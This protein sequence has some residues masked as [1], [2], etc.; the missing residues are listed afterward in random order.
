[1]NAKIK[2]LC[3][4]NLVNAVVIFDNLYV[5]IDMPIAYVVNL[6]SVYEALHWYLWSLTEDLK[7]VLLKY[8]FVCWFKFHWVKFVP[9][10]PKDPKS[11]WIQAMAFHRTGDKTSGKQMKAQPN[12]VL[13][14]YQASDSAIIWNQ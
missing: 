11:T 6:R 8:C 10:G 1:M 2:A 4:G 14:R 12:G 7:S 3:S 9:V 13:M 5:Y